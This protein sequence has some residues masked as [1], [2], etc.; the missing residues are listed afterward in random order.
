VTAALPD[1]AARALSNRRADTALFRRVHLLGDGPDDDG[2]VV[3]IEN[4]EKL[5]P[6]AILLFAS[7]VALIVVIVR[8][9]RSGRVPMLAAG[10][11]AAGRRSPNT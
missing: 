1:S 9:V 6:F 2:D 5:L 7:L 8:L 11:G 3:E 10:G 4:S